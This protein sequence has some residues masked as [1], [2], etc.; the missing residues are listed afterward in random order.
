M[1]PAYSKFYLRRIASLIVLLLVFGITFALYSQDARSTLIEQAFAKDGSAPKLQQEQLGGES[2]ILGFGGTK[3]QHA[4]PH[5]LVGDSPAEPSTASTAS[6]KKSNIGKITVSFGKPD[7]VFDRAIRSHELHNRDWSYPQFVLRERVMPGLYSKHAY[8]FS[9]IVQELAK[10]K[11][12]RLHWVAY[13]FQSP[14]LCQTTTDQ[15]I[16]GSTAIQSS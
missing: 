4:V 5:T 16:G 9:I 10:P 7:K 2:T 6:E 1:G 12:E 14:V 8:I 13:V 15:D 11:S 3:A